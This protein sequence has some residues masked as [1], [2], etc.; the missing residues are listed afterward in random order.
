MRTSLKT[1]NPVRIRLSRQT[2]GSRAQERRGSLI[3]DFLIL[4][5]LIHQ[6]LNREE[7]PYNPNGELN[8]ERTVNPEVFRI[9]DA[10]SLLPFIK[11]RLDCGLVFKI[12]Q[13]AVEMANVLA[14]RIHDHMGIMYFDT[15][16][17]LPTLE[18]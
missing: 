5:I 8:I 11:Y 16:D 18:A 17:L 3:G 12:N 6:F 15:L 1:N 14:F 7:F 4:K 2:Q 10:F 13:S 9:A